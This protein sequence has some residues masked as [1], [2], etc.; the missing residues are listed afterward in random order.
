MQSDLQRLIDELKK[1]TCPSRVRDEVRG[2]ISARESSRG[3]LR[4]AI[5]AAFATLI[6]LCCLTVAQWHAREKARQQAK[7]AERQLVANQAA[8]AMGLVGSVLLD[9]GA[10]SEKIISDRTVP[11]LRNSLEIARNKIIQHIEL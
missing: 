7:L 4:Y 5:A 8:S 9:A 6:L 11:Q 2:R 10:H 1:E 3:R